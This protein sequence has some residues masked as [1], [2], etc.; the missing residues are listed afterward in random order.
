MT[1]RTIAAPLQTTTAPRKSWISVLVNLDRAYRH[2]VSLQEVTDTL[3]ED[4]G[5][6]REQ[7]D[8][9]A[10]KSAWDAPNWMRQ[11]W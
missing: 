5:L 3:L 10:K 1:T 2:R 4:V 6:T 7:L 9:E 11:S 8:G